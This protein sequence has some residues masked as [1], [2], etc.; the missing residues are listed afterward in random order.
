MVAADGIIL[1]T[2]IYFWGMTAQAKA[3]IDRTISGYRSGTKPK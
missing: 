3:V 2:P 1:G